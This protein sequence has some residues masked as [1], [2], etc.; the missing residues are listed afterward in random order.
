MLKK[1][2]LFLNNVDNN[3]YYMLKV[4]DIYYLATETVLKGKKG[5]FSQKQFTQGLKLLPTRSFFWYLFLETLKTKRLG[6]SEKDWGLEKEPIYELVNVSKLRERLR[7][8][9]AEL[10]KAM[11]EKNFISPFDYGKFPHSETIKAFMQE[12]DTSLLCVE[13]KGAYK[14]VYHLAKSTKEGN[15]IIHSVLASNNPE[16]EKLVLVETYVFE[17]ETIL[18]FLQTAKTIENVGKKEE[19]VKND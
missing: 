15:L 17:R 16:N 5:L 12:T 8:E 4:D 11:Q 1:P 7:K 9:Q 14:R 18:K 10:N 3:N 13:F 2:Y 6:D 19:S